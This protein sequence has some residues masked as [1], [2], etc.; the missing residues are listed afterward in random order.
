M[1]ILNLFYLLILIPEYQCSL[2]KLGNTFFPVPTHLR[3]HY[4]NQQQGCKTLFSERGK[5][6]LKL[7]GPAD[8]STCPATLSH[9]GDIEFCPKHYFLLP[10]G[11]SQ[12]LVQ[13][14]Q[15]PLFAEFTCNL[16]RGQCFC[17]TLNSQSNVHVRVQLYTHIYQYFSN[18]V[19][20]LTL[21]NSNHLTTIRKLGFFKNTFQDFFLPK[22]KYRSKKT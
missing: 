10:S 19:K 7:T 18:S 1:N 3:Q 9:K 2:H 13:L 20:H 8:T 17:C 12:G 22:M 6:P 14:P 4:K 11:A 21:Q 5:L 15:L 16:Q